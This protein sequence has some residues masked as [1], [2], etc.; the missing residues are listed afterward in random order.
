MGGVLVFGRLVATMWQQEHNI[1]RSKVCEE[2]RWS[3]SGVLLPRC[4]LA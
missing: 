1:G 2:R 4:G 3:L